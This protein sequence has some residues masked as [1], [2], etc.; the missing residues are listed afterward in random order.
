MRL[1]ALCPLLATLFLSPINAQ[2]EERYAQ[3]K[4]IPERTHIKA[5]EEIRIATEI[6]LAKDWHVYWI[7]P[8]DSGVPVSITWEKPKDIEIGEINW[9]VPDKI[10]YEVLLNYGYYDTATLLQTLKA[11]ANLP[12]GPISL[13]A[14]VDLLVC[15]EICIPESS[16]IELTLN[17][18]AAP[19]KDNANVIQ[20][21][22]QKLP[23]DITGN[24]IYS[25]HNKQLNIKLAFDDSV[26]P[27]STAS[28]KFDFF[29]TGLGL[30]NHIAKPKINVDYNEI[31]ISYE[32]GTEKTDNLENLEGLLVILGDHGQNIGYKLKA[33]RD[34]SYIPDGQNITDG[35]QK[36][37]DPLSHTF[38]APHLGLVEALIFA[39][40]GGL[41]LNLMPCVFPVLS[42]KALSLV[43]MS[44]KETS[45]ARKH[46]LAYTAG[47]MLSFLG[48]GGSLI[49]LKSAGS[50]IGWGFQL[51]NPIV[52]AILAYM[53]FMLGLNLMGFFEIGSK[54]GNLGDK[55]TRK[56][57]LAGSF[58]TGVLATI[59]ATPCTA[60][61]M[62]A[63]MGFALVQPALIGMS[64]F[65]ALGFGLAFPYLLL[66][67]APK[68]RKFLPKP[69]HWM[70]TFK[71]IL[72]FPMFASAIWLVWVIAQQSGTYSILIVQGSMLSLS[73]GVYLWRHKGFLAH[74]LAYICLFLPIFGLSGLLPMPKMQ[75]A[76][77]VFTQA[78]LDEALATDAPVFVEMTA[79]WCI[80]CKVNHATSLN[81]ETTKKVFAEKKVR[82]LIGDWTNYNAEITAYLNQYGRDGVPIYVF[83][84]APDIKTGKRP[85]PKILPQVLTPSIVEHTIKGNN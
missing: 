19:P 31:F 66:S 81:I 46:G 64:V 54:L 68:A 60:P 73:F 28:E 75:D 58:F 4:L 6:N 3:V 77:E 5:G 85:E 63:A 17:D 39:L 18:P 61:F 43:K 10:S 15:N 70:T 35:T 82:Y 24:F 48:I 32:R 2:A 84:G 20:A 57:G 56:S 22:A 23:D 7:N 26:I 78:T 21:A 34:Q 76:S 33:K 14:K 44:E 80:T 50:A 11:P 42:M 8:G 83:Y 45:L 51:Q 55:L 40:F 38:T 72:A 30:I 67:Y 16:T 36:K 9:P 1:L 53:L 71:Q 47:V 29:P 79:A 37:N 52:V 41:I 59:V 49:A 69:G 74:T 25:D 65:A 12:E 27:T 13:I 62:G